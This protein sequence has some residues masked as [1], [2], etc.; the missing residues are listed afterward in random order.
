MKKISSEQ[1]LINL[2]NEG[3]T[4]FYVCLNFGLRSSKTIIYG[5]EGFY[6]YHDAYNFEEEVTTIA[7]STLSDAI[8]V[9]ALYCY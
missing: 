4:E 3:N 9:G 1:D 8:D 2:C 7:D 5:E 6:I